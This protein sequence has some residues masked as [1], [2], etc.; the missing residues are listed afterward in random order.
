[1]ALLQNCFLD[2]RMGVAMS[3]NGKSRSQIEITIIVY[4]PNI[5]PLGSLPDDRE[6][7]G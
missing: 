5:D 2:F 6:R 4:I 3:G 7:I 1:M